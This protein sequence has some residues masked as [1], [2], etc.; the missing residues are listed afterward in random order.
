M[1]EVKRALQSW[2]LKRRLN[3]SCGGI[4]SG[5]GLSIPDRTEKWEK[6]YQ[7]NQSESRIKY[8]KSINKCHKYKK[9]DIGKVIVFSLRKTR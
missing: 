8:R 4:N 1:E 7:R 5:E 6:S 2:E 3:D 9:K